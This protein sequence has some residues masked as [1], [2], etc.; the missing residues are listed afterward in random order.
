MAR[1]TSAFKQGDVTRAVRGVEAAGQP[2]TG[3][4][5]DTKDGKITVLT[6]APN[7]DVPDKIALSGSI[8]V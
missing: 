2:I 5:I 6:G 1:P 8:H 7:P 4:Q 3:V